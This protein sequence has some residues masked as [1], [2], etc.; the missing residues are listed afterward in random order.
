MA[1]VDEFPGM[2]E[3]HGRIGQAA[4][5]WVTQRRGMRNTE[6]VIEAGTRANRVSSGPRNQ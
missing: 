2:D 4:Q 3:E 5:N 1:E 6:D